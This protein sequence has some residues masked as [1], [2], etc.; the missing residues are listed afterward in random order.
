MPVSALRKLVA[1]F[2]RMWTVCFDEVPTAWVRRCR[3][4][5][6]DWRIVARA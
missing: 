4:W 3:V 6:P 2:V 1:M 5:W